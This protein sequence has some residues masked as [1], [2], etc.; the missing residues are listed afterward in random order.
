MGRFEHLT[1]LLFVDD[2]L[3]FCS[4]VE[5]EAWVLLEILEM[6]YDA[7][8]MVINNTKSAIYFPEVDEGIRQI[9]SDLFNF[10]SFDLKEG[11]KYLVF[12]L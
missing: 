3:I 8:G 9:I 1:Q 7:T 2:V 12:T 5:S 4:C 6:F 10:S 11:I